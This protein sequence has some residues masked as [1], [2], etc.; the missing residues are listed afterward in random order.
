MECGK[1]LP[2]RLVVFGSDSETEHGLF[3]EDFDFPC[4]DSGIIRQ[5]FAA[6]SR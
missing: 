6:V 5:Q 2:L 3:L 4:D 1:Q